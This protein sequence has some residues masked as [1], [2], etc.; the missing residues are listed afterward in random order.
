MT[1][2]DKETKNP[3]QE[4]EDEGTASLASITMIQSSGSSENKYKKFLDEKEQAGKRLR[5]EEKPENFLVKLANADMLFT[6]H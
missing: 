1:R 4:Q 3:V 6:L 5:F 2:L